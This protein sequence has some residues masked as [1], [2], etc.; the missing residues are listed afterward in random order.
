MC[1]RP[2]SNAKDPSQNFSSVEELWGADLAK[3]T[4]R[5]LLSMQSSIP[6][7]DTATPSKGGGISKDPL[8]AE[9][10]TTPNHFYKPTELMSVE[11]VFAGWTASNVV[12]TA[13]HIADLSWEIWKEHSL[14]P[15]ALVKQMIPSAMHIYGMGA[16]NV[17][18]FSG[19]VRGPLGQGYGHLGAT[20]GCS[21]STLVD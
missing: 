4:L 14:A 20:Y 16:F 8:R 17:G 10:Y 21:A 12:A 7:F 3:T 5:Q 13:A 15:E 6:D 1:C 18:L 11:G 19:G 9:L 2:L